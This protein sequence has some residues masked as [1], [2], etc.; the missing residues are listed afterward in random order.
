MLVLLGIAVIGVEATGGYDWWWYAAAVAGI[1]G[2]VALYVFGYRPVLPLGAAR[3][4]WMTALIIVAISVA[5]W[6]LALLMA[7]QVVAHVMVWATARRVWSAVLASF[8]VS[9]G[10]CVGALIGTLPTPEFAGMYISINFVAFI[11]ALGYGFWVRQARLYAN[12]QARLL[13]ELTATQERLEATSRHAG[14]LEERSRVSRE[15]HDTLTQSL[16]GLVLVVAQTRRQGAT[17][18]DESLELIERVARDAL[19]EAR[20]IVAET[21]PT[22]VSGDAAQSILGVVTRFRRESQLTIVAD[23]A[24]LATDTDRE[25]ALVRCTQE[26]LANVR[27]HARATRAT[28]RLTGGDGIARLTITDDGVGP[29]A[30]AETGFGLPGMRER[31]RL[32]GGSAALRPGDDGG[33]ELL[34]ELPLAPPVEPL[35][36]DAPAPRAAPAP[37]APHP[38]DTDVRA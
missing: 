18:V 34:V 38:E 3:P 35:R 23:L 15:L 36:T 16:S 17:A 26:G 21:A 12:D 32:L 24:P 1:A 31:V 30:A 8:G 22:E 7:I 37:G 5:T 33:T 6:G 27:K 19:G 28:V 4:W 9:A 2:L 25:L 29:E 11:A 10:V 13:A 20:A 14:A